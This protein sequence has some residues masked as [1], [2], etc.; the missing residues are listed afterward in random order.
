MS[1]LRSDGISRREFLRASA[2]VGLGLLAAACAPPGAPAPGAEAPAAP[3]KAEEAVTL[4]FLTQGGS[5]SAFDRYEPLIAKFQEANPDIKIEPI[6]EPGGAI[7][8]QTKLLTLIAAGEGPDTYWAHTYTNA[9]QAK[10]NIQM[11]LQPM[12]D[13]DPSVNPEDFLAGAWLDFNIGGKQ[14]GIPR[15]TTSTILIYNKQLF[16]ENGVPLPSKDWTWADFEAAA[17]ALTKG[18]GAERIYG[19]ADWN[20]N[21]NTWIKM[22]QKG[23]DVLNEDRT[24]FI[25]NQE[26]SISQVK[27]IQDWHHELQVHIP[28]VE[29]GGFS[30]G[31]LFTTGRIGMFP[32]FSV[33][34]NVMA[35]EFE[36]DIAHLP[37]DPGDTRTTRVASAGHSMY[38]GTK[39]PDAAWKW[40][41]FLASEEAF[42]H[43]VKTGLSVPSL[44]AVAEDPEFLKTESLPPSAHIMIEAFEYGRPEPVAGDWIGVHREVQAALDAIY[45]VEKADPKATL[46]AIADRVNE[47]IAYVPGE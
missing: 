27:L 40:M 17:K 4:R 3:E 14:I 30:T 13:A 46:D 23:G 2:A 25:M 19:T 7:E 45:G 35:S 37:L 6:W 21:R 31:D 34:F 10:R 5:Q 41:A 26:P 8:I 38:S 44:R 32:Q 1:N 18:E 42:W 28:G 12:I 43:F 22:W 39:N 33:F 9:G 15:E 47:L 36:W 16:E 29:K 20:L 24:K 11:D